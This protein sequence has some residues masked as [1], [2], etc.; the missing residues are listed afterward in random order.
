MNSYLGLVFIIISLM[1]LFDKFATFV[2][3]PKFNKVVNGM[4]SVKILLTSFLW[5]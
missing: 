4:E 1:K 3:K 2:F 5:R